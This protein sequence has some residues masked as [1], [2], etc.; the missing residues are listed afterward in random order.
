MTDS[1][2]FAVDVFRTVCDRFASK[3]LDLRLL[4]E[5]AVPFGEWLNREAFLAC[6]HREASYP[7]C[8]VAAEPTYTS[9]GVPDDDSNRNRG[10]L[11]VGGPDNGAH[12]CWA[13][14]EF[15]LVHDGNRAGEE[16]RRTFVSVTDRLLRLGWKKSA[17]LMIVVTASG[18]NRSPDHTGWDRP[19]LTDPF[20]I[21]LPGGGTVILTAFDIKQNPADTLVAPAG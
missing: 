12:H 8:E 6:K 15:V 7:F 5:A 20:V 1:C 16:W 13:F 17:A 2:S 3:A 21:P 9:E 10:D 18:N 14:A 11:R 19:S 4:V